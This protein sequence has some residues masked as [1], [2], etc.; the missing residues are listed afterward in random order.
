MGTLNRRTDLR[1]TATGDVDG[2]V[3]STKRHPS[4]GNR[5]TTILPGDDRY[6]ELTVGHNTR[7]VGT[8]DTIKVVHTTG[9]VVQAVQEAVNADKRIAVRGGGHCYADF[10]FNPE[11]QTLIDMTQLDEVF[12]DP[13]RKSFVV[14]AGSTLLHAYQALYRG[15]GVALP[16][17]LCYSVG[18]GGHIAGGGFGLL[19][20]QYGITVDHLY[21]VEIVTV[22]RHGRAVTLV[23][24]CEKRDPHREL[25]WAHTGGGGGNFGVVTRYFFRTP[26]ATGPDPADQLMRPPKDVYLSAVALPWADFDQEKFTALVTHYGDWHER[27]SS[28]ESPSHALTSLLVMNHRSDG[29]IGIITQLDASVPDAEQLIEDYLAEIT[30]T[31]GVTTRPLDRAVGEHGPLPAFFTP[32]KLPWLTSVRLL[33]TNNPE[34]TNP[35]L[36]SANKSAY[37]R[38]GFTVAQAE[39][40]YHHLTRTDFTNTVANVMLFGYGSKVNMVPEDASACAQRDSIF[41]ALYST[42]WSTAAGDAQNSAWLREM[43]TD[44][45]AGSGGYP[46]PNA[47]TDGCYVNYPDVDIRDPEQNTSGVPWSTLYYKNHYP[48]LQQVKKK[49]DPKNVFRH[50]QSIELP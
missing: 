47:A 1:D 30:S 38:K 21:A 34:L 39:S 32:R 20:R 22:N 26:G 31:C 10:V 35:T 23:A 2:T 33:G 18:M 37:H 42:Q 7:W 6:Q 5:A 29:V 36:R 3:I 14:E 43:Y 13:A 24:S 46:V 11:V 28:V 12:Y 19:S 40:L 15:W 27:N 50:S 49:Y 17:G 48:R 44:V 25:W 4:G 45:Y 16:G 9:Q 41:K 8:P